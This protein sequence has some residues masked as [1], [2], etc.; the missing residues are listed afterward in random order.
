ML[1]VIFGKGKGQQQL[2]LKVW[3]ER[4]QPVL[5][6]TSGTWELTAS[7]LDRMRVWELA[8]LRPVL[9]FKY[10]V[11]KN[12][13]VESPWSFRSRT[14]KIIN[15]CMEKGGHRMAFQLAVFRGFSDAWNMKKSTTPGGNAVR[16]IRLDKSRR[17]WQGLQDVPA[18]ERVAGA[19]KHRRRG[20]VNM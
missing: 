14:S 3:V 10:L 6:H 11:F 4:V 20:A 15:Q 1:Y 13:P 2:K 17:W 8:Q 16:E 19:T 18:A 5:L 12:G 7:I 9:G